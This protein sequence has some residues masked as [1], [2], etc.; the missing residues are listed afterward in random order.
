MFRSGYHCSR[1][2][3]PPTSRRSV[4]GFGVGIL[5]ETPL[6]RLNSLLCNGSR[7]GYPLAVVADDGG[8]T[9]LDAHFWG[10]EG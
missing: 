7:P 5:C 4:D 10:T 6:N 9:D 1:S 3:M 2:S 8:D